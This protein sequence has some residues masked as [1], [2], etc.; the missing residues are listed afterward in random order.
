MATAYLLTIF[1]VIGG[2]QQIDAD[3]ADVETDLRVAQGIGQI[4]VDFRAVDFAAVDPNIVFG[5]L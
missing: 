2:R 5:A 1:I 3:I 4:A